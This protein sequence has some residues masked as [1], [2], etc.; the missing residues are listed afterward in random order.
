MS[1]NT[2]PPNSHKKAVANTVYLRC[3][4]RILVSRRCAP[5]PPPMREV[6]VPPKSYRFL[7]ACF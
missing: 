4:I 7:T 3:D 1:K 5:L 6:D 2:L